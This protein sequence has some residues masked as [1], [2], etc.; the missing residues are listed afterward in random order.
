MK[1]CE[2][3]DGLVLFVDID[4]F[5]VQSSTLLQEQVNSKTGFKTDTLSMLEQTKRNCEY[6]RRYV[7]EEFMNAFENKRMPNLANF[8]FEGVGMSGVNPVYFKKLSNY[9]W[10]QLEKKLKRFLNGIL[11][12]SVKILNQYFEERDFFLENDNLPRGQIIPL[13]LP[14]ERQVI[15]KFSELL[16]TYLPTLVKVNEFSV[17]EI[18]R[19]VDEAKCKNVPGEKPIIPA[20]REYVRMDGNDIIKKNDISE[21][22]SKE[23][24]YYE[25]PVINIEKCAALKSRFYDIITNYRYFEIPSTNAIDYDFIYQR[26]H[27]NMGAIFL[28]QKLLASGRITAAYALSHHN[29]PR[30][31][32]AKMRLVKSVLPQLE[33]IGLRF[34]SQEHNCEKRVRSSKLDEIIRLG[35]DP[36]ISVLID[37][38]SEN[39]DTWHKGEGIQILYKPMTDAEHINGDILQR[40]HLER[41][42]DFSYSAAIEIIDAHLSSLQKEGKIKVKTIPDGGL[43]YGE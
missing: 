19:I 30:E 3:E 28:I 43:Y 14:K 22:D 13:N 2:N 6:F 26:S 18:K 29:G 15:D 41:I 20:Y 34:H 11:D 39:C 16:I 36:R 35:F 33:F 8:V 27:L 10:K 23:Y 24:I 31:L 25:K 32:E 5:L 9:E 37:D 38:S 42:T 21:K 4:D 17:S 1:L 12:A 40:S 7:M